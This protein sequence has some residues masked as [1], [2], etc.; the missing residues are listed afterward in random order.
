MLVDGSGRVLGVNN[1]ETTGTWAIRNGPV[2]FLENMGHELDRRNGRFLG[3][4]AH[5]FGEIGCPRLCTLKF[6]F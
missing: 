5:V 2:F 4:I 1:R 3:L 6:R